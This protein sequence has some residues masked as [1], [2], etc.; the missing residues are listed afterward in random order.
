MKTLIHGQK[1]GLRD[2]AKVQAEKLIG[3]FF[4][5]TQKPSQLSLEKS[6]WP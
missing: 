4:A 3:L 6:L 1:V 5:G 2:L